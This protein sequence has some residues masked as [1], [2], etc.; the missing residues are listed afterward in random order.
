VL[1]VPLIVHGVPGVAPARID[2][3]VQLVDL[4]PSILQWAGQPIPDTFYGEP[5]PVSG[6]APERR[7]PIAA[8]YYDYMKNDPTVPAAVRELDGRNFKNCG[9]SNRVFD[10]MRAI[11]RFPHKL[12]WYA[13]YPPQLFD[14]STDPGEEHDLLAAQSELATRLGAELERIA[15]PNAALPTAVK[16]PLDAAQ[17]ERLRALGYLGG[18]LQ[19]DATPAAPPDQR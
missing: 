8:F 19:Q 15:M 7:R 10:D 1:H 18:Q 4:G 11:I 14:L 17:I 3:P 12:L 9:P 6:A 5:L 2:A 13:Q 16:A